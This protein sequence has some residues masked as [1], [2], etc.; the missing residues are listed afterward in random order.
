M[1]STPPALLRAPAVVEALSHSADPDRAAAALDRL[2]DAHRG[3]PAVEALAKGG[4]RLD[5]LL[6]VAGASQSL[7]DAVIADATLLEVL[8]PA[9][10][11][12][13]SSEHALDRRVRAALSADRDPAQALRRLRRR[14]MLR[15]AARDLLGLADLPTVGRELAAFASVCLS[16][17]LDAAEPGVA[18][19]VIG[20]GKL[21]GRELNYASDVDVLFVHSGDAPASREAERVAR[22]VLRTMTARTPDGIVFR[23]DANLRPEGR[24]GALSR[25]L[26]SYEAYWDRWA[27]PW[28]LQAL[29]KAR[30]VA[31]DPVLGAAFVER[32]APRVWPAVLDRDR[33]RAM[34]LGKARAEDILARQGLAD[35]DVKRGRGGIRDVEFAVQLLQLVHGRHDPSVRSRGTLDALERLAAA[36]YLPVPYAAA[37]DRAYVWL[38]TVEHRLQLWQ[39]RQTHILPDDPPSRERLAR[40]LGFRGSPDASAVDEFER[41]HREERTTVRRL[42]EELFFAPVLDTLAGTGTMPL[43]AAVERLEAFGFHD[44]AQAR[45]AVTELSSGLARRSRVMHD[46]FPAVLGWLADGPDPDLGLLQLRRLAEGYT[47]SLSLARLF[48]DTPHGGERLC[49]VLG[50]SR[51]LG[52]ALHR[53]PEAIADFA[54]DERLERTPSPA[55]VLEEALGTLDWRHDDES[56]SAGLRRFKRRQLLRI[57]T[58]DLLGYADVD[59]VGRELSA[60]A[61]AAVEAALRTLESPLPFAVIGMGR[62]GGRELA[63]P[64]DI[65]VLFVYEGRGASDFDAA[66]RT[67]T[68]LMRAIG[69][70]TADGQTWRIDAD[71]RPE[72]RRGVLARSLDGYREYYERWAQLWELQSLLR[73]RP[74]AGDPDLG[75][76]FCE[77]V[78]R[79]V[80]RDDFGTDDVR[81]VRRMKARIEH[82]RI[83]PGVDARFHVKLGP[84]ALSDVEFTVQL[85]QL[86]HG[87]AHPELRTPSTKEGLRRLGDTGLLDDGDVTVLAEAYDLCERVRNYR[88]LFTGT[89]H[90]TLPADDAEARRIGRMLG[91]TETPA[92]RLRDDYR[93]ATRRARAVVE[94]VFYGQP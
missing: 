34:R 73:A 84:G 59:T 1:T 79:Y 30:P 3:D 68:R 5:A 13:E 64:S 18:M 88:Y 10:L 38:R 85:L 47:R 87:A 75:A 9:A 45:A 83:P 36:G 61:D 91:F 94:R 69:A 78:E 22:A 51:V 92:G 46:L 43:D 21:G 80:Y 29:L 81:E 19:T 54:D 66:E 17:A 37:L 4:L 62:L 63:Y 74:I 39:E 31:G 33:I 48:R 55:E 15:I 44:V 53:Q 72:G 57:G 93:R 67:A 76:R 42:H 11:E 16:V 77:L 6:A 58:R 14:E 56:R 20:M 86:E 89:P 90:D 70:T 25:T 65:D 8:D 2:A 82:E 27:A 23:T 7:T 28:E 35:R 40:V 32:A 60:V 26:D 49:R 24:D 41:R 12:R 71:L 52:M 50:A